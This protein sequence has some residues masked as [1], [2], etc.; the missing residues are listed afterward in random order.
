MTTFETIRESISPEINR[1]NE[2]MRAALYSRSDLL[3]NVVETYLQSKGK[4][5][6]PI[7]VILSAKFFGNVN[8]NVISGAAAIELL[9]NASLIHD[10]VIDE[11]RTRR[12]R[13]TVN[14]IWDNHIAVLAGDYFVSNAL[15]CSISTGDLR[16]ISSIS[17]LG[18]TLST[19]EL[20]QIDIARRHNINEESY[21]SIIGR[22]TASLFRSCV[23]V[24]G[25]TAG[26]TEADIETLAN[27]MEKLGL[28]FQIKDDIFDYSHDEKVGKPT[29]NDLREGKVT[30]PLLYALQNAPQEESDRMKDLIRRGDLTTAEIE[31]LVEFAKAHGGIDDAFSKMREMQKE[32][33]EIIAPLPD[34]ES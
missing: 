15:Q 33:D 17:E 7:I 8:E 25:Y 13:P 19:G 16:V 12:G 31:S 6:R 5:I 29:G 10:D 28:C 32:A 3:N 1:L 34:S 11:T 26:A 2:R 18:K 23:E 27:F 14:S 21:F 22:K 9:H 24:G 30:L 4:Q 20:D